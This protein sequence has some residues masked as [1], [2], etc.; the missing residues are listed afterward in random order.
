M[1]VENEKELGDEVTRV[2][3]TLSTEELRRAFDHWIERC[4]WVQNN[5]GEYYPEQLLNS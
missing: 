3:A 1:T 5:A 2:L 4:D